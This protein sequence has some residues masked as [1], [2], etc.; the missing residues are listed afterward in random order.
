MVKVCTVRLLLAGESLADKMAVFFRVMVL[1]AALSTE[2]C[3]QQS[4]NSDFIVSSCRKSLIQFHLPAQDVVGKSV[5]FSAIDKYGRAFLITRALASQCG[6]TISQDGWGNIDFRT[7]LFSCYTE[8][9]NDTHYE[10]T[11]KIEIASK[12]DMS[13]AEGYIK[14][15]SCP[16]VW[17]PREILCETNYMEVSVRR[18]IPV[19]SEGVFR[20]EPEDWSSAIPQA[21]SG[22][23]SIWQ[24]V[25]HLTA[26]QK[27]TMM[28]DGAQNIGYG[29]NTTESRTLLRSPYNSSESVFQKVGG[30]TFS[31][32][33]ATLFYKQRWF[34]FLVDN[35]VACPVDDV[36]Y[37]RSWITWTIPKNISPLLIGAKITQSSQIQFGV[38]LW[39]LTDGE[40]HSRRY[41]ITDSSK[42][43]VVTIPVG[44]EGGYYKSHV[45]NK[46]YGITY[47]INPFLENLWV[48][49]AWGITKYTI[50]K[51]M[52]TP[53]DRRPPIITNDTIPV[54][55]IFNVTIGPFLP[56]VQL[57]NLTIGG[58]QQTINVSYP[59]STKHHP[60]MSSDFVLKVPF[61][62]PHVSKEFF[63]DG[64]RLTLNVV[65]G[66]KIHPYDETFTSSA[67][68]V[69]FIP[70]P[71]VGPCG[72]NGLSLTAAIGNLS[73]DWNIY[74]E[75]QQLTLS[76]GLTANK[77]HTMVQVPAS[78]EQIMHEVVSGGHVVTMPLTIKD[79]NG[80]TLYKFVLSCDVP[81]NPVACFPNGT[82]EVTVKKVSNI[83]DMDMSLLTLRDPQCAPDYFSNNM[84][85]FT[86]AANS[87]KTTRQ[88]EQDM[89]IYENEV[90]YYSRTSG[91]LLYVMN[92]TCDY[93]INGTLVLSY[94]Y[95]DNPTPSAQTAI[96]SID[97][98]LRLSKDST[99]TTFYGEVDY[100]VVKY[101]RDSLYFEVELLYSSDPRLE[102]FLD[103]CWATTTSDMSSLP[104]WPIIDNSCE[105]NEPYQTN[106][107]KVTADSRVQ[108]PSHFK[109]FEV[110]TFTF[111]NGNQP[112]MGE[113]YFHC[114]VIICDAS[115]LSSD[116]VCT[117]I[118]SCIPTKQRSGR[119]I[120]PSDAHRSVS[121]SRAV[122]LLT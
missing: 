38:N 32:I 40:I 25:F 84:A 81:I 122:F 31:T 66:F 116:S 75:E 8:I 114:N 118:G 54:T 60:N 86:F 61:L 121:T 94:G 21:V 26:N 103:T 95:D 101:L 55:S 3:A 120:K 7:S 112:Y 109:R 33:R 119:S 87:C 10:V 18:K 83:P 4:P 96:A 77:T 5:Q 85:H 42:A 51:Q 11:V 88:F 74:I 12:P 115:N 79:Q 65:F 89:M 43:T 58:V 27:T 56:D 50:V 24:V 110:K 63:P 111:M 73:P 1:V 106:F 104:A 113:I 16:Y 62:D 48:D 90:Y 80:A 20:D 102:L 17:H 105:H 82:I 23:M 9:R 99:Y 49:D 69:S 41:N 13:G 107:Y 44:A 15:V 70:Q 68:I 100:P 117:G 35:A 47:S 29:I 45:V 30:V 91:K 92:V 39:N 22:L 93:T 108:F 78:S 2:V 57:V 52:T 72:M 36:T 19:I 28:I 14:V 34:I 97:L 71:T 37:T 98:T 46:E 59:I 53:F 67:T 76:N 64:I 6:Y